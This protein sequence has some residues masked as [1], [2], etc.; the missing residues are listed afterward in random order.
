MVSQFQKNKNLSNF[1]LRVINEEMLSFFESNFDLKKIHRDIGIDL[2]KSPFINSIEFDDFDY[3]T[4]LSF[5]ETVG[6][7]L[8]DS[9]SH[10]ISTNSALIEREI[11]PTLQQFVSLYFSNSINSDEFDQKIFSRFVNRNDYRIF[12]KQY[13]QS[14]IKQFIPSEIDLLLPFKQSDRVFYSKGND[15]SAK[16]YILSKVT[17][18]QRD[19]LKKTFVS[20]QE[21]DTF[22]LDLELK[23]L[24]DT[25]GFPSKGGNV[26]SVGELFSMLKQI[27]G[28]QNPSLLDRTR[29]FLSSPED[30]SF[31]SRRIHSIAE[32]YVT[33]QDFKS[34]CSSL[35]LFE[36]E[37]D[38]S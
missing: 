35:K 37:Y 1:Y 16:K 3:V 5:F 12:M 33:D 27:T 31:Y 32:K 14:L 24:N 29:A 17:F 25:Y 4:R 20:S 10:S 11:A 15:E 21:A 13:S 28:A 6:Q 38:N 19:D 2:V 8:N 30:G 23:Q 9:I 36:G 22:S 18:D 7:Y 34:S 26:Y